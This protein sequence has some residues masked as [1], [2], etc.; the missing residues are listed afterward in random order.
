MFVLHYHITQH[1]IDHG[2][3]ASLSIKTILFTEEKIML[4]YNIDSRMRDI[5]TQWAYYYK[6]WLVDQ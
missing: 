1:M 4:L 2:D 6:I 3:M 5:C